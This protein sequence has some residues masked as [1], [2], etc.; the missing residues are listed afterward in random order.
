M[1]RLISVFLVV[2]L[3]LSVSVMPVETKAAET[4]A[5]NVAEATNV[6]QVGEMCPCGCGREAAQVQWKPWNVN[7]DGAPADGH[8][9]LEADYAQS[10]Q[11]T[12]MAGDRVVID[13]RGKT[14]NTESYSRLFLVYGHLVVLDTVGG[15]RMCSKTSGSAFGGVVMVGMNETADPTFTLLSG[16][17]TVDADNKSSRAGGLVTVSGGCHFI[18]HGGTLLG[19]STT[20]IGGAIRGSTGS[21]IQILGGKIVGCKSTEAGG[22]ICAY[23]NLTLKNCLLS[24][25]EATGT[26][27]GYGGNIYIEG[28]SLTIENAIIENGV[29]NVTGNGGGNI[30]ALGNCKVS[31]KDSIIRNGYA[32][33]NGG[34]LCFGT[35]TQ[36]LENVKIYGGMAAKKGANLYVNASGA[37]TTINGGEIEGD[38]HYANAKLTLKGAVKI[39]ANGGAFKVG[40]GTLIDA[41]GLT[42]GAEIYVDAAGTFTKNGA[43]ATYFKPA[44][45][46]QLST[47]EGQLVGTQAAS[48]AAGGYCSHCK[49]NV[50]WTEASK[51]LSGHCY[52]TGNVTEGYSVTGNVVLDLRGYSITSASRAFSVTS[53][54]TLTLLDSAGGAVV[55]G[56][57]VAGESGGVI[58]NAGALNIYGGNYVYTAGKNVTSGGVI[59]TDGNVNIYG[60]VFNGSAFS[61]T[62]ETAL[63]GVLNMTAGSRTFTMTTGRVL[64]GKAYRGGGFCFGNTNTVNIT[65]GS[66]GSGTA[67]GCGGN[68]RFN[69]TAS[70]INATMSH[71]YMAGGKATGSSGYAGNIS[72]NYGNLTLTDS[73]ILD[74]E[75]GAYGGNLGMGTHAYLTAKDCYIANG[76]A[77]RGGNVYTASY[78]S[79]ADFT[80]CTLTY[81]QATTEHGGNLRVNMGSINFYGGEISYG[82]AKKA[83]GNVY[84]NGGNYDHK[85]AKDDGFRLYASEKGMPLVTTGSAGAGG[86][87]GNS[88]NLVLDAAFI[89]NG[90]ATTGKDIYYENGK[91]AYSL[92]VGAK[93]TGTVSIHVTGTAFDGTAIANSSAVEFPGKLILEGKLGEPALTV[94]DGKL[95]LG[96]IALMRANGNVDW[97]ADMADAVAASTKDSYIKIFSDSEIVLTKDCAVDLNGNTLTVSGNYTLYGMDSSGD[98]YTVGTGK[99]ILSEGAKTVLRT[100]VADGREYISILDGNTATYHRLG[101][102]LT[103]VTLRTANCGVFYKAAWDCDSVLAALVD[104]YGIAL[105][106]YKE[107]DENFT[108]DELV[109]TADYD[110][111]ELINGEKRDG[112]VIS[113]IMKESLSVASNDQRGQMPI[114]AKA[115]LQLKDGTQLLS[116]SANYSLKTAMERLDNLISTDPT[117][118]RRY[119]NDARA[120]YETWK[121]YGMDKWDFTNLITPEEDDVLDI[122]MIGSSGCYYYVEELWGMLD[123]VGIKAR[124]CNVYYSGC[125]LV[126]HYNWW[127]NNESM[128]QFFVTDENGRRQT[129]N[130]S[131]EYCLAQGEWDVLSLQESS[132]AKLRVGE[133][134][135]L[136]AERKVYLDALY[137]YLREQFPKADLYWHE[138]GAYQKGYNGAFTIETVEQQAADTWHFREFAKAIAKEYDVQWIP[139]GEAS[140]IYREIPGVVDNLCAR[141]AINNGEGD[142]YHD[143]DIGGGQYLTATVWFEMLTGLSIIGNTWRP[144]YELAEDKILLLQQCGHQ[145]VEKVK[146]GKFE[147]IDV[148]MIGGSASYYYVEEL[149]GIAAAAGI[150]MR[151]CNLYY[152][153]CTM[154]QHY[155]WWKNDEANYQFFVTDGNGRKKYDNMSL[156]D[157]LAM[158]DWEVISIQDAAAGI[159]KNGAAYLSNIST[160]TDALMPFLKEQFPNAK[161]YWNQIW[162]Y[163]IGYDRNGE[164]ITSAQQQIDDAAKIKEFTLAFCERYETQR[165][166]AGEAWQIVRQGGYDNLCARLAINNGEGDYYHDGDIG[167]GQY[168]NACVWLEILT[169]QSCVGNTY[170]PV[171]THNGKTYTLEADLI[172][173]LQNAAHQ[174]V[175]NLT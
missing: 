70:R 144:D 39:G 132:A 121:T 54:A 122:L 173:T 86:N 120:F 124:V 164:K 146:T 106:V 60:G 125:N 88:G 43:D 95:V 97:F 32:A 63:G 79:G 14:L 53:G 21:D 9:Y 160:Y 152:S 75:V 163:Q 35:C 137:G 84:T 61:N 117:H 141:L 19:G 112:I 74:G 161:F 126:Q 111:A 94:K 13:L 147:T 118:F 151:V 69:G 26:A 56:S 115:Y 38:V 68:I 71:V 16:T 145:A 131:L 130:V 46:T 168:L 96:G 51:T 133:A 65:G 81:G 76:S 7:A 157:C 31:I 172:K 128:Y 45:R 143:G 136:L 139:R 93:L 77:P 22:A 109:L 175:A 12:I 49:Q 28:G 134:Q 11:L 66:F 166:N 169:G 99:A 5:T 170:S 47:V 55:K 33:A 25:N 110:G 2:A 101:M 78:L 113:N 153:G 50:T 4:D 142:Y 59:Y 92:T 10:K 103:D 102:A 23:G 15:G 89:N 24:G 83:G 1:K 64:G 34:N 52:L 72:L 17:L 67:S 30:F 167:G 159:R 82:I 58:S 104:N 108:A 36:T 174:A 154:K 135:T 20:E 100:T 48:G 87:I 3:L 148:L 37:S 40:A 29:S 105:S 129:N 116:D 162:S 107:P 85:D 57:G 140:Q 42:E 27:K 73:I 127:V 156:K 80:D 123:A 119:T 90:S 91:V 171:Y 165:I 158:G 6:T 150:P 149:Y 8:Y 155:D 138:N 114:Y 44:F 62:A 98:D 41:S 18:M